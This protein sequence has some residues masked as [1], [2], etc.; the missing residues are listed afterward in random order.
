MRT[1][2][3]QFI[4]NLTIMIIISLFSVSIAHAATDLEA[5]ENLAKA[6]AKNSGKEMDHASHKNHADKSLEFRG[7]FYGYLPCSD[8]DGIKV[9][10]SLKQKNNYLMVT[11]YARESSREYYEKGKYDWNERD[12]TVVLTPRKGGTGK[13]LYHIENEG[14]IIQLNEDGSR[15][16]GDSDRYVLR[17]SD[18]TKTREVHIH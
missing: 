8:C 5:R 6:R 15:M 16:F 13:R 2:K 17:R 18:M 12:R 7:V 1:L 10:L 14:T 3:N 11:Q 4:C 9:T